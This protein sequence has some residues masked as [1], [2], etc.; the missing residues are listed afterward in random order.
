MGFFVGV[1]NHANVT[2]GT[3]TLPS[4]LYVGL[5]TYI[6]MWTNGSATTAFTVPSGWTTVFDVNTG[7]GWRAGLF[8][9]DYVSGDSNPT[10]SQ[11]SNITWVTWPLKSSGTI[12]VQTNQTNTGNTDPVIFKPFSPAT[13]GSDLRLALYIVGN[14]GGIDLTPWPTIT[15]VE[16]NA[17]GRT[18]Q[19]IDT[20]TVQNPAGGAY[21]SYWSDPSGADANNISVNCGNTVHPFWACSLTLT[22]GSSVNGLEDSHETEL[23]LVDP[24]IG[25]DMLQGNEAGAL[26]AAKGRYVG[27]ARM[28]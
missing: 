7:Q 26:D 24:G 18:F 3:V 15:P 6:F 25:A 28:L 8:Y 2:G 1:G 19:K 4:G 9:R 22:D 21:Y 16:G 10:F 14:S 12:S 23:L 13:T 11:P 17:T 27:G 5:R 20:S